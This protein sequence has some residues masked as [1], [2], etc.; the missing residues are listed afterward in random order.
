MEECTP[1]V[2]GVAEEANQFPGTVAGLL[3][4]VFDRLEQRFGSTLV[5]EATTLVA[6]SRAGLRDD[7]VLGLLRGTGAMA[8]PVS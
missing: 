8:G 5:A 1:L 6:A 3:A 7:E 2:H 4:A